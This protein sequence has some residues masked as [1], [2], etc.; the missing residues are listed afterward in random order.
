[1]YIAGALSPHIYPVI[2]YNSCPYIYI[3]GCDYGMFFLFPL[4]NNAFVPISTF[5]IQLIE[6]KKYSDVIYFGDLKSS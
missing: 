5:S 6:G 1:M 2:S 4:K 3:S